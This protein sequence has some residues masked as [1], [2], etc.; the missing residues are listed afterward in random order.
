MKK[1]LVLM[2]VLAMGSMASA[3]LSLDE[4]L[5]KT[6]NEI[7]INLDAGSLNLIGYYLEVSV[8]AGSLNGAGADLNPSGK[9]WMTGAPKTVEV[10]AQ[11]FSVTGADIAAFGGQGLAAPSQI[12]TGLFV[13]GATVY[14][15]TLTSKDA[16]W[17]DTTNSLGELDA[18]FVPE[19]ISLALLG[20]GGLFLRRRK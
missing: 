7:V 13:E 15:V 8:D 14:T 4:D 10:L 9:A 19:P 3:G 18:V 16:A 11:L 1:L 17:S 6:T 5:L 20:L 2:L 12:L